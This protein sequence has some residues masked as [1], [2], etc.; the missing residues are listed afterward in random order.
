[1]DVTLHAS[2]MHAIIALYNTE[3]YIDNIIL[4]CDIYRSLEDEAASADSGSDSKPP[5]LQVEQ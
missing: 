5:V 3:H 1:M 2:C 4:L